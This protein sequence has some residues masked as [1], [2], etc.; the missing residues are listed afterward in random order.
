MTEKIVNIEHKKQITVSLCV[1]LLSTACACALVSDR[2]FGLTHPSDFLARLQGNGALGIVLTAAL[3]ALFSKSLHAELSKRVSKCTIAVASVFAIAESIGFNIDQYSSL[4]NPSSDS[5]LSYV[6]LLFLVVC[7]F[8]M[9]VSILRIG[10]AWSQR[11]LSK[12]AKCIEPP[13]FL[14]KIH[15]RP[16]LEFMVSATVL[17]VA[18]SPY[19]ILLSPGIV[20]ADTLN[21]ISQAMGDVPL[22]DH[23]PILYTGFL[24]ITLTLGVFL[25]GNIGCGL[26]VSGLTQMVLLAGIFSLAI[27]SIDFSFRYSWLIRIATLTFFALNPLIGWYSI[28]LWKDVLFSAFV[29]LLCSSTV[30]FSM[31]EN[32][33]P[34]KR[35]RGSCFLLC[36]TRRSI[37]KKIRNLSCTANRANAYYCATRNSQSIGFDFNFSACVL[38]DSTWSAYGFTRGHRGRFSRSPFGPVAA[39]CTSGCL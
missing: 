37:F 25:T 8:A 16:F 18:W 10:A 3:Y 6:D 35:A 12:N 19:F 13:R 20:T 2:S 11:I 23:N 34:D 39:G 33:P 22:S 36:I 28:T 15:E 38:Y 26:I 9:F 30:S 14:R 24:K 29:L 32:T 17:L 1:C 21:E 27:V 5:V 7:Y 31:R 4:Q